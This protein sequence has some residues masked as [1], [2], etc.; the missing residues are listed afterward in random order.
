L[1]PEK[2]LN[3]RPSPA[4]QVVKRVVPAA[5]NTPIRSSPNVIVTEQKVIRRADDGSVQEKIVISPKT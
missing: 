1:T 4:A 3:A 2:P 5:V